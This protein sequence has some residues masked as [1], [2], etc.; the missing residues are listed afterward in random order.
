MP[1]VTEETYLGDLLT[2]DGK[3]TKNIKCR[4]SKGIGIIS[5][6]MNLLEKISFGPHL[7]EIAMLLR[8]SMLINGIINNAEIWYNLTETEVQDF[9][10]IDNLFFRRLL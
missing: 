7:F 9:E 1:E 2:S 6:I 4:V 3:N 8:D 5:Q 10:N